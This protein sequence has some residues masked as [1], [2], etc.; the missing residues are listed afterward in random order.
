MRIAIG[1]R[2]A[3]FAPF[4]DIGLIIVDEEHD[5]SYKQE[6]DF[7]YNAR[8]MAVV[9]AKLSESV[10]LLG[11][12]TPSLQSYHNV[13]IRKFVE[14]RLNER[15][16]KRSLP[17][18]HLVDLRK[19][20][21][22][23]GAHRFIT[24]ALHAAMGETLNRGEQSLIFLN[25]RGFAGFPLCAVCGDPIR[26][27]NCDV[28][29]TFHQSQKAYKC[30]Y[31]GFALPS[32]S[33]CP[34]CDSPSIKLLGL[35]TEKLESAITSLFPDARVVR[36]DR[37]TT[38]KKGSIVAI[39]KSLRDQ[40]VD[41]LVGTQMVAK[42]HDFPNITLVGI[43]CA[44]L[45]LCH[46][47][48]RAGERTFQLLAQVSGR[49]GRGDVP[50]RVILQTYNPQHFSIGAAVAQDFKAFYDKEIA[51]R[52][53]LSYPPCSRLVQLRISGRDKGKTRELAQE[54]G[55]IC[56]A[57]RASFSQSVEVLGPVESPISKIAKHYRWQ[58][59]L[60]ETASGPLHRFVRRMMAQQPAMFHQR[61][62][63][64]VVDVDPFFMS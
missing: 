16:E 26:C 21:D 2:S 50:G 54:I 56:S 10:A 41:I 64:V 49:A 5:T 47:D 55:V 27:D 22:E 59:L 58:I 42:G 48:F 1:A 32:G 28:T 31:C 25:R 11:S 51:F 6:S 35:G 7:A 20:R 18:I 13:E 19:S 3:I 46:P 29:L 14:V 24:P 62:I 36:M 12:A 17:D 60:K 53:A 4:S 63:K 43:I 33:R 45:S 57:L 40:E 44:D 34:T 61:D 52:R 9:R 37:D 23:R 38:T 8:D 30:H 15:V 39:L